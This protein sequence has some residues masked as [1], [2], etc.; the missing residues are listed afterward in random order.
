MG[1]PT[2]ARAD[3]L[4]EAIESCNAEFSSLSDRLT[5]IRGWCYIIRWSWCAVFDP[6]P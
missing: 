1:A 6:V 4:T 3:C 5:G 2:V